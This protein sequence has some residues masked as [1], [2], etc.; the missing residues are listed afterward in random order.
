MQGSDIKTATIS[1]KLFDELKDYYPEQVFR[2]KGTHKEAST[3]PP[4]N[5]PTSGQG[6]T[7]A[8]ELFEQIQQNSKHIRR[9]GMKKDIMQQQTLTS[10]FHKSSQES[11][12][13]ENAS[14][15]DSEIKEEPMEIENPSDNND[16]EI[17]IKEEIPK[18]EY[19]DDT[20]FNSEIQIDDYDTSSYNCKPPEF[21]PSGTSCSNSEKM[22]A[23]EDTN[24][25]SRYKSAFEN[26]YI[27][28]NKTKKRRV[29]HL[30]PK[31]TNSSSYFS[32]YGSKNLETSDDNSSSSLT[33]VSRSC[34]TTSDDNSDMKIIKFTTGL[35]ELMRREKE[36]KKRVLVNDESN[37]RSTV[38]DDDK[39]YSP[40][41][42][43]D[44]CEFESKKIKPEPSFSRKASSSSSSSFNL[45]SEKY[46]YENSHKRKHL[47]SSSNR[48]HRSSEDRSEHRSHR[49][50]KSHPKR[51]KVEIQ[52]DDIPRVN[53]LDANGMLNADKVYMKYEVAESVKKYLHNYMDSGKLPI[54][55]FKPVCRNIVHK[56]CS[57]PEFASRFIIFIL[58]S[59][60]SVL[61][62]CKLYVY[63]SFF[64]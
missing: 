34:T 64:R 37:S 3:R 51:V 8:R 2:V 22:Y 17:E 43:S 50:S 26:D 18:K 58:I 45:P 60:S 5:P 54:D 7:T 24:E 49:S 27:A 36:H 35:N 56:I 44:I 10:Y 61:N 28:D 6:I 16:V 39:P 11:A 53:C 23:T 31:P 12:S 20:M 57:T 47:G 62:Y 4:S 46:K 59:C 19:M 52:D 55:L 32:S 1:R 9:T 15:H 21:P 13:E 29:S 63:F 38:D 33:S 41:S 30:N 48:H 14:E 42:D 40:G 25:K